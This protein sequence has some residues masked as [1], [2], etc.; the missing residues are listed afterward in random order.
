[1][2]FLISARATELAKTKKQLAELQAAL[3]EKEGE[4]I[5]AL[6]E[7]R[8]AKG[9]DYSISGALQKL[10]ISQDKT[11][12]SKGNVVHMVLFKLKKLSSD[13]FDALHNAAIELK[14]IPGVLD[15]SFGEDFSKRSKEYTHGLY[16]AF[17]DKEAGEHY[18]PHA[19]H[20]QFKKLIHPSYDGEDAVLAL[21]FVV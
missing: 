7:I 21:D 13:S 8:K 18:G 3:D 9:E 6:A 10:K 11:G 20:E 5:V 19:I 14:K 12:L 16:V 4:L 2:A 17:K 15:L 1:L